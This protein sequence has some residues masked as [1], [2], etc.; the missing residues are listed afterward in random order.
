MSRAVPEWIGRNDDSMP[1]KLVRDR[2]SR[3][4]N[5]CCATCGNAFRPK[6]RAHC[7]HIVPLIDAGENR[8]TNMQM[9]CAD[10]HKAKTGAEAAARKKTRDIRQSHIMARKPSA[11]R[12][13]GFQRSEPQLTASSG[14]SDKFPLAKRLPQ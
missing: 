3:A 8:E 4:Q 2:L 11:M 1:G 7:D 10:C 5:D 12:G 13:A 6:R 14:L 9:L